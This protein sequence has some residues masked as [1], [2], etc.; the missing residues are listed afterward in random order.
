MG[1]LTA[2]TSFLLKHQRGGG[3]LVRTWKHFT[4][5]MTSQPPPK[6][7]STHTLSHTHGWVRFDVIDL[8][9]FDP[10]LL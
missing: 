10:W 9:T 3:R 7:T 2:N 5:L 6:H 4:S 8:L 1:R